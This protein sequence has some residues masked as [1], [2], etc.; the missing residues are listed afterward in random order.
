MAS[1]SIL[2]GAN[3]SQT[4]S[5]RINLQLARAGWKADGRTLIE[6]HLLSGPARRAAVAWRLP[7]A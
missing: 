5:Q 3:E 1:I 2:V 6:E 7:P 4:P